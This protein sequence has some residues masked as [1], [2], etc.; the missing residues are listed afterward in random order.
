MKEE[1]KNLNESLWN[2]GTK[3]CRTNTRF[4]KNG[5]KSK[6]TRESRKNPI[7][8]QKCRLMRFNALYE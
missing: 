1:I 6:A 8:V 2:K 3:E 5:M 4:K 7:Y